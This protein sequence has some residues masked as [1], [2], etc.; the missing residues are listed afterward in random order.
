M[1]G[2]ESRQGRL[3]GLVGD[4]VAILNEA[5]A[6][7]VNTCYPWMKTVIA[8]NEAVA[9][10]FRMYAGLKTLALDA[11]QLI[12]AAPEITAPGFLGYAVD[13]M[14][15]RPGLEHL[16]PAL[17]SPALCNDMSV[18]STRAEAL[19]HQATVP[20]QLSLAAL[21]RTSQKFS[22]L[23][24]SWRFRPAPVAE[25]LRTAVTNCRTALAAVEQREQQRSVAR[26]QYWAAACG[27]DSESD[28]SSA[29]SERE[30]ASA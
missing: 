29:D 8:D 19:A 25:A 2:F 12:P 24:S 15:L 9:R 18:W 4:N 26:L 23:I 1:A 21:D 13:F 28:S 11:V 22:P 27:S 3:Y 7:A 16:R 10:A 30:T 17:R 5:V 14:Q 6:A 20:V